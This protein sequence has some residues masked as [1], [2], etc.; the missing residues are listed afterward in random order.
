MPTE[1]TSE[2]TMCCRLLV[3]PM[4]LLDLEQLQRGLYL[5]IANCPAVNEKHPD[6]TDVDK[7]V[8]MQSKASF[9]YLLTPH[10]IK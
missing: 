3:F 2:D 7:Q 6:V 4:L 5:D 9:A 8:R 10:F 1:L